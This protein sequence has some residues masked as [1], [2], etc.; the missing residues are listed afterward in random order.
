MEY[1][2]RYFILLYCGNVNDKKT[3]LCDGITMVFKTH[4]IL[5]HYCCLA[6]SFKAIKTTM[7]TIIR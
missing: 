1:F 3:H 7:R 6:F 5:C 4:T 2:M